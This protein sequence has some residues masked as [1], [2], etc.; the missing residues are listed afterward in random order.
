MELSLHEIVTKVDILGWPDFHYECKF[1]PQQMPRGKLQFRLKWSPKPQPETAK[2]NFFLIFDNP[3][4]NYHKTLAQKA[5]TQITGSDVRTRRISILNYEVVEFADPNVVEGQLGQYH[6]TD[7]IGEGGYAIVRKGFCTQS[8]KPVAV[9][10][11]K[12]DVI[13]DSI[14]KITRE[15]EILLV[16]DYEYC[17][18]VIEARVTKDAIYIVMEFLSGGDLLDAIVKEGFFTEPQGKKIIGDILNG[19]GYL[20]ESGICHRDLK[21]ENILHDKEND[22]WK[23]AD[24]GC[25]TYCKPEPVMSGFEGTIQ[26][27]A[28]ELFTT[29]DT[30]TNVIDLWATGVICYVVLSGYF[31]WQGQSEHEIQE[32]ICSQSVIFYSPEFDGIGDVAK[33]F[34]RQLL[35]ADPTKRLVIE[36]ARQHHWMLQ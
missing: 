28:P 16:V 29:P 31:P 7:Q 20:H 34:M 25:A 2:L 15:I 13:E 6:M 30:Y 9:K 1:K 4:V 19:L 36:K 26:Y 11:L 22:T 21:P 18:S 10:V 3:A 17:V 33:D 24:F 5:V 27:M 35:E 8:N 23:I 12:T 14:A 32:A